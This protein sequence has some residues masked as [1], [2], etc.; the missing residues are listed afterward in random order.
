[1]CK[2]NASACCMLKPLV[3]SFVFLTVIPIILTTPI[4]ADELLANADAVWLNDSWEVEVSPTKGILVD[5]TRTARVNTARGRTVGRLQIW[6]TFYQTLKDFSG[7]VTDTAGGVLY[8]IE[9]PDLESGLPFSDYRL[10][11][12][13]R[14]YT[15]ELTAPSFPY[16][17]EYTYRLQINNT[18]FWPDWVFL[19]AF[20]R[21]RA[22]YTVAVPHLFDYQA[23]AVRTD[24]SV[25]TSRSLK[26]DITS[27]SV[28]NALVDSTASTGPYPVLY[29]AP[30]D[31]AVARQR[32]ST[33]SWESLGRWYRE[34]TEDRRKIS[35]DQIAEMRSWVAGE[36]DPRQIAA[37]L[38]D[39]V[40]L[41]WRY[42]AI[43]VGI[44]G[45]RPHKAESVYDSRYGDCKDLTFLW[46][47]ML[48]VF[49]IPGYPALV[50]ARNPKPI[51][52][53]FPKDWFD[54]VIG[55]VVIDQDTIW[56]DLTAPGYPAGSLPYQVEDRYALVIGG[57]E[58]ALR[59]TTSST[60]LDNQLSRTLVGRIDESGDLVFTL[61]AT[62]KGHKLGIF[63]GR[64]SANNTARK[65]AEILG[66]LPGRL[67]ADTAY[68]SR[69]L[70]GHEASLEARGIIAEW[71]E[72]T[73]NRL[74][75]PLEFAGWAAPQPM[76][77][78][79][80]ARSPDQR[81]YPCREIDSLIIVLPPGYEVEFIPASV[82]I[83][84]HD[85]RFV[86]RAGLSGDTLMCHR[87]YDYNASRSGRASGSHTPGLR[88][89][90]IGL[91]YS[92]AVFHERDSIETRRPA[93]TT[94]APG[95]NPD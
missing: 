30:E 60:G 88:E 19:D 54:H 22:S 90:M 62:I 57:E 82:D 45:W 94:T 81:P 5:I 4:S 58:G 68:F 72:F 50:R 70:S 36:S 46:L 7:A 59:K 10:Y 12:S 84:D 86:F 3:L 69:G 38:K 31:F 9:K 56:A 32:G 37:R 14:L 74:V 43:E 53:D 76:P 24:L 21:L 44:G 26:R 47:A 23:R 15:V 17:V 67:Q 51:L 49:D 1:V 34:L 39:I 35:K 95:S 61:R 75:F 48:D 91:Q 93:A 6:E 11:S 13:D 64:P 40:S 41:N 33:S 85:A 63:G 16:L 52:P 55:C 42:V 27:W 20:P 80:N 79:E 8:S 18:F 92:E 89:A 66:V 71:A 73:R 87:Y 29:L 78:S 2:R 25:G 28:E 77:N 65:V 83:E